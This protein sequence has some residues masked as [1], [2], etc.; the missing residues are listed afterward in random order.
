MRR[1]HDVKADLMDRRAL[2]QG[3]ALLGG[4]MLCPRIAGAQAG[5]AKTGT[6][7]VRWLGGGVV[8]LATPDY[9]QM[10]YIDAWIW[11]NAG[12]T[13]FNVPKPPEYA[14]KD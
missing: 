11:N 14:S 9:K 4:L 12:W 6:V 13:R 7:M 5:A 2:L 8:E 1:S 10:A 3:M